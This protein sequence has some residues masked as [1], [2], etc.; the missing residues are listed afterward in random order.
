M[1]KK[2]SPTSDL[3]HSFVVFDAIA[4]HIDTIARAA[5]AMAL[6]FAFGLL[7]F[8]V[9]VRYILPFPVAWLEEAA[10]YLSGYMAMIGASVCLRAGYHLQVD[11]LRDALPVPARHILIFI[12]NVLVFIFGLFLLRYGLAFVELG[13][14]QTSPSTFF[15]VSHARMAMPIGGVLLMLQS[16]V[17]AGRSLIAYIDHKNGPQDP[18]AGGQITD[19]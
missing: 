7:L 8:Q 12:Q 9:L 15:Q 4:G 19:A 16:M 10:T 2:Q 1:S 14:G 6:L 3:R 13:A 18:N 11:L 5:I 17:M